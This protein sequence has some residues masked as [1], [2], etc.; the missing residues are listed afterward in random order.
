MRRSLVLA[1]IWIVTGLAACGGGAPN[2]CETLETPPEECDIACDPQP[3][4]VNPCPAGWHC[5]PDGECG[6]QCTLGGNEC[7]EGA[8]CTNDGRCVSDSTCENLECDQVECPGGGTTSLSGVVYAPNGTLPLYNVTV[9]IPNAPIGAF[10]DA[11]T[12]DQCNDRPQGNPLVYTAT[13]TAGRFTLTDVPAGTDFPL[14]IQVGRW[15]RQVTIPAVTECVDTPLVADQT[16]FPRNRN[17]GDIPRM[18]LSTG[19]ADSLECLFRKIGL[20]DSEFGTAGGPQKVHLYSDFGATQGTE[21]R[22]VGRFDAANGGGMFADSTSLWS[23]VASLS[24]YDVT[25]LS[26]EGA[27]HPETKPPSSLAA[28]KDYTAIGG[29]AFA[30]HWHNIWL[31][32]AP[33]PWPS[34]ITRTDNTIDTAVGI[35][36]EMFDRGMALADWLLNVGAS[37]QRGRIPLME[38]RNTIAAVDESRVD[39][40]ISLESPVGVEYLSFTTP[41]EGPAADRCGRV[42]FSDIHVSSGDDSQPGYGF[43]SD[44]CT[45]NVNNLSPQEKVLAFMIFDI[46][47]CIPDVIE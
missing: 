24:R 16:R 37:T 5:T 11:L 10:P 44:G 13:D 38:A 33:A 40:W 18:A 31:D 20:D 45:T 34:L 36:N 8:H 19:N 41:I 43:P 32:S 29:R 26:C 39:T 2:L 25:I 7:G 3:G 6:F 30:S 12:C 23:D 15:R 17:E 47:S 14:V 42:V 46:A 22:G 35:V 1:G 28:L 27:Q 9:Y 4:A 21:G